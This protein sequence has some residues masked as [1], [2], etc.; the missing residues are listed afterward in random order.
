MNKK[1][2][3]I[4]ANIANKEYICGFNATDNIMCITNSAPVG[5][6]IYE[7]NIFLYNI[8]RGIISIDRQ[9]YAKLILYLKN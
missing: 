5:I 1:F 7:P 8:S 9:N 3:E 4:K 6:I 2:F